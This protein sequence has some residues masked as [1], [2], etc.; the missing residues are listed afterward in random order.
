MQ[1]YF[2]INNAA[3]NGKAVEK[4]LPQIREYFDKNG[5][6]YEIEFTKYK[7]DATVIARQAAEK[8]EP[9]RIYACGGDGTLNEVV[10]GVVGYDNVELGV[11]PCGSGNDFVSSLCNDKGMR[12]AFLDIK[13][14]VEGGNRRADVLEIDDGLYAIN[15]VSMGFDAKVANNFTKFKN[16]KNVSGKT[17]YTLSVMYT[18]FGTLSNEMKVEIDGVPMKKEKLLLA[19]AANGRYQGGGMKSAPL[20]DPFNRE[21]SVMTVKNIS[22]ARFLMLFPTYM[23]GEHA[24]YTDFV[25]MCGCQTIKMTVSKPIPVTYDGEILMTESITVKVKPS[26]LK[27]VIPNT[28]AV[29]SGERELVKNAAMAEK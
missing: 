18:L 17:A 25:R 9:V 11:I 7:G 2:I 1:H 26:A 3:G 5:G 4:L 6:K 27:I 24:K 20:A 15:Q 19:I 8:G 29:K 16:K 12:D 14:Q 13:A 28:V 22:R 21:I 10:N 23:K